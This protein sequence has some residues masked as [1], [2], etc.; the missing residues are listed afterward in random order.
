[1]ARA[2]TPTWLRT[3]QQAASNSADGTANKLGLQDGDP[4]QPKPEFL[5][6]VQDPISSTDAGE[7]ALA[8]PP[9][10]PTSTNVKVATATQNVS[11]QEVS[12]IVD[13]LEVVIGAEQNG[14]A[15][16]EP[17]SVKVTFRNTSSAALRAPD[18][19]QP[20]QIGSW[21]LNFEEVT[22]RRKFTGVILRPS[23][24]AP[25]VGDIKPALLNPGEAQSAAVTFQ[26]FGFVEGA[27]E[28]RAAGNI[29]WDQLVKGR[30]T[31]RGDEIIRAT[32]GG[33]GTTLP[34]EFQLP[35]GTYSVSVT[36]QFPTFLFRALA[37]LPAEVQAEIARLERDPVPIWKGGTIQSNTVEIRIGMPGK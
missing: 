21:T 13:G 34:Q 7:A 16:D 28:N 27:F 26:N 17:I 6:S 5:P 1:L 14:F 9:D 29:I 36:V 22:T 10:K 31:P 24:A 4:A 19:I 20:P 12:M 33:R 15:A 2:I 23:G 30:G 32:R 11:G 37:D 35:P 8:P 25:R 3:S 18:Q